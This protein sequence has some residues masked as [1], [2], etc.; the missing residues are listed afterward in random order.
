MVCGGFRLMKQV[1]D[2][3]VSKSDNVTI[4]LAVERWSDFPEFGGY[5]RNFG[6][7]AQIPR[8]I[9]ERSV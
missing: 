5:L 7:I 9:W 1:A 6:A 2:R 4:P 8:V 3:Y